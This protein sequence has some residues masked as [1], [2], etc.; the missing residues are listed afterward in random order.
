MA[1]YTLSPSQS[2]DLDIAVTTTDDY[3]DDPTCAGKD[4]QCSRTVDELGDYCW[5]HEED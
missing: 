3:E 2:E 1:E 5:Q 4:G